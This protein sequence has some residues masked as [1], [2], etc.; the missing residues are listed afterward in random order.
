[1]KSKE[2]VRQCLHCGKDFKAKTSPS[3]S[4]RGIFCSRVCLG[5]VKST[6]HGHT[7]KHSVSPTYNSWVNMVSRCHKPYSAKYPNYGAKGIFVC[8]AWRNSFANFLKDM[9]ERPPN[10]TID[11]IDGTKGYDKENCRWASIKDQQR[12]TKANRIIEFEGQSGCVSWWVEKLSTTYGKLTYRIK[13]H[14]VEK[15]IISLRELQPPSSSSNQE[16][17]DH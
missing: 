11:R 7:T 14:G 3:R 10:T 6:K 4:G 5:K 9:G 16:G 1:M 17:L 8:D 12:N 2:I 15:A 13:K